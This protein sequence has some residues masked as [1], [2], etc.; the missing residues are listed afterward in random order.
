M[1]RHDSSSTIATPEAVLYDPS[2]HAGFWRRLLIIAVDLVV[3]LAII[4]GVAAAWTLL[5]PYAEAA[6]NSGLIVGLGAGYLYWVVLKLTPVGTLGYLLTG[7]KLVDLK[8]H[9]PS[10]LTATGRSLL[11]V[12]FRSLFLLDAL[13]PMSDRSGQTLRDKLTGTRVVKRSAKPVGT[14]TLALVAFNI[15]GLSLILRE[16][17]TSPESGPGDGIE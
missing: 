17:K 2:D 13:W 6:P 9:R 4:V 3:V 10:L 7:A 11:L 5:T 8:G 16:V 15:L 1:T 14:G 12:G